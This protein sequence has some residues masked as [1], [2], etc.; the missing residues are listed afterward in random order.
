MLRPQKIADLSHYDL[1]NILDFVKKNCD[2]IDEAA[3]FNAEHYRDLY[4]FA[5]TCKR[6]R[7]IL[8]DW[9]RS[10]YN[11]LQIEL[12]Q[13]K[14]YK[15]MTVKFNELHSLLKG[16]S[17]VRT[18]WYIDTIVTAMRRNENLESIELRYA[19]KKYLENHEEIFQKICKV[20][21]EEK[22]TA[23]PK[24]KK[25]IVNIAECEF[26]GLGRFHNISK[27]CLT[28]RFAMFDLVEFCKNNQS[29]S[30]LEL[31][32][33][34]YSDYGK[35]TYIVE[36][37]PKLKELKFV[38][39]NN[40]LI[41]DEEYVKLANLDK[42]QQLE[43]RKPLA[44]DTEIEEESDRK[45]QRMDTR[46]EALIIPQGPKKANVPVRTLLKAIADRKR[47]ILSRLILQFEID[48]DL[49]QTIE[50]IKN[51]RFLECGISDPRSIRHL[52]K[53][54]NLT[55]LSLL[56][57]G[58]LISAD[59][60][61]LVSRH[62]PVS[63]F[64]TQISFS[65]RGTLSLISNDPSLFRDVN[66]AHLLNVKNLK[67][68]FITSNM[69]TTMNHILPTLLENGIEIKSE[70]ISI[71]FDLKSQNL[72][73]FDHFHSPTKKLLLPIVENL[74]S[75]ELISNGE[76][77]LPLLKSLATHY[78]TTLQEVC[79]DS[80]LECSISEFLKEKDVFVLAQITSLRRVFCVLERLKYIQ[81][82]AQLMELESLV[83]WSEH[84][85]R[86]VEFAR[87]MLPVL[88]K[89]P[90]LGYFE[91][92]LKDLPL[93]KKFFMHLE[94]ALCKSRI[95]IPHKLNFCL[96]SIVP[97]NLTKK[98][99]RQ[100]ENMKYSSVQTKILEEIN[101]DLTS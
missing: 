98:Q 87:W 17:K 24:L 99:M 30:S 22:L 9:S 56:N 77:W 72:K 36:H 15:H 58:H 69:F 64:D 70:E 46:Y 52:A 25:F 12:L 73:I 91:I 26:V 79:I 45:R 75:F 88:E 28:A 23:S 48:D 16:A 100:I 90:K 92:T 81:P 89:C 43:V 21:Q 31:N 60:M 97:C 54:K 83:V 18:D 82:L 20:I 8:R 2:P 85:P 32:S 50:K 13:M 14:L 4:Y 5:A 96:A 80:I 34:L 95:G 57:K 53:L 65:T 78:S 62:I 38:L 11:L 76:C 71:S 66:C 39:N 86:E 10:M 61:N 59:V 42:L 63:S 37:C 3:P 47:Q 55:K 74:R 27:L 29:L 35:L 49:A 84:S 40:G 1:F 94:N 44:P 19:P 6:H 33:Y 51:L 67:C 7:L 93:P 68:L 41:R 101:M